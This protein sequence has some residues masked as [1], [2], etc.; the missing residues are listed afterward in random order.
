MSEVS[1]SASY[2][3]SITQ[4]RS[5]VGWYTARQSSS[6]IMALRHEDHF[7]DCHPKTASPNVRKGSIRRSEVRRLRV[8]RSCGEFLVIAVCLYIVPVSVGPVERLR[9]YT[10]HPRRSS[11]LSRPGSGSRSGAGLH[12][13]RP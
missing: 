6:R 13:I 3:R 10:A 1:S 7:E 4:T 11:R 9:C 2:P 12:R 5:L 8:W